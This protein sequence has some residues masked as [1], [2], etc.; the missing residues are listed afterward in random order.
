MAR[1]PRNTAGAGKGKKSRKAAATSGAKK[2]A[3]KRSAH[4]PKTTARAAAV[5]GKTAA[6]RK[7]SA[8]PRTITGKI[9]SA[10]QAVVD[11]VTDSDLLHGRSHPRSRADS[12]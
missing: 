9:T 3:A 4:R 11:A 2:V 7:R 10:L 12:E 6:R 8:Q 5:Q 1:K